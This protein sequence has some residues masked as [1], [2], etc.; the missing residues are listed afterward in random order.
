M[1]KWIFSKEEFGEI[2]RVVDHEMRREKKAGNMN[3]TFFLKSTTQLFYEVS[4]I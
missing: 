3:Q 4:M 2:V 1:E